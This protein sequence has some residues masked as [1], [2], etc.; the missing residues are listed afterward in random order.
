VKAAQILLDFLHS[1]HLARQ[2]AIVKQSLALAWGELGEVCAM[3]ALVELLAD[4]T[5]TVRLHAIAS[6]K[7]FPHAYQQLEQLAN[8]EQLTPALKQGVAIALA[9]WNV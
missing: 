4:P 9:E 8:D 5:D 7:N 2:V 6:L 1:E 3:E